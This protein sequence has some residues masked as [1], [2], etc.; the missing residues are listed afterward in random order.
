MIPLP[1]LSILAAALV[2]FLVGAFW[3]HPSVFGTMWMSYK[4]ITPEMAERS[5]NFSSHTTA[6][7]IVLGIPAAMIL[8]R[9]IVTLEIESYGGAIMTAF[10]V[11]LAFIVPA[12][13]NRVL[14][15]HVPLSL[16]A[17]ETGQW[18]VSLVLMS[19]VLLY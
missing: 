1:L 5:S 4:H 6:V 7:M 3:Y 15:D 13:I 18:L 19:V 16:Y 9:I 11:W 2:P 12:T 8:S 10:S 17:I 14:W